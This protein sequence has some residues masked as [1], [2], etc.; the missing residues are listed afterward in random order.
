SGAIRVTPDESPARITADFETL[1]NELRQRSPLKIE[2]KV[3]GEPLFWKVPESE[4]IVT[5]F[6]KAFKEVTGNEVLI[7]GH[8]AN[9]DSR[10]FNKGTSDWHKE[11]NP[12]GLTAIGFGPD[13]SSLHS[14]LE[15][16][17]IDQAV[18]AAK[19]IALAALDFCGTVQ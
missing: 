12:E 17:D 9:A 5:S 2:M 1:V 16:I 15:H 11:Y 3:T 19:V 8:P 7:G 6:Q 14:N 18:T 13:H 4:P 10:W